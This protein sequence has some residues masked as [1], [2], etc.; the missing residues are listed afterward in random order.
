MISRLATYS[1]SLVILVSGV[2]SF[3]LWMAERIVKADP[4]VAGYARAIRWNPGSDQYHAILGISYRDLLKGQDLDIA[5][6]ELARA[7][8]LKPRV[9]THHLN[10]ALTHERKGHFDAAE[11]SFRE[12]LRLNPHHTQLRWQ[13]ANFYLRQPKLP[14]AIA[15]FRA[16]VELDP[17]RLAFAADRLRAAGVS[18][19]D[20]GGQLV[21]SR[22]P[23]LLTFL[24]LVL[25]QPAEEAESIGRL[26]WETWLRWEE[27]PAAKTT[28]IGGLFRY[29]DYLLRGGELEKARRVW[30]AGLRVAG[31]GLQV[32]GGEAGPPIVFNGGFERAALN[33]G[34]DWVLPRHPEVYYE[35]DHQTRFQGLTSLR[36]DFSGNSNLNYHGP[37]QLLILPAGRHRLEFV[38]RS[39]NIT[40]DQGICLEL[41]SYPQGALLAK[42]DPVLGTR[43]WGRMI[44]EF[45]AESPTAAY[46]VLRR[47]PSQKFNNILSGRLWLD[48]V[49]I[50]PIDK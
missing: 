14:E 30:E 25:G 49:Q 8:E 27:A 10:L 39:E 35:F 18:I 28:H 33:G 34:M 4:T 42:S 45:T 20:I 11:G 19:E 23:E 12:A 26:A 22:R 13:A 29:V 2:W 47:Y 38:A 1:L 21:P 44:R 36:I 43:S 15:E 50:L 16:A 41:H 5:V 6:R 3:R 17:G 31:Y 46:L 32:E 48:D 9:W 24:Y 40:S 37:R 7:A